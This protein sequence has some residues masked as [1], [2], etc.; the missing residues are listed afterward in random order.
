MTLEHLSLPFVDGSTGA[1]DDAPF[2]PE[3]G[4]Q[5]LDFHF[6]RGFTPVGCLPDRVY[7]AA[8]Q[9]GR[10]H[11]CRCCNRPFGNGDSGGTPPHQTAYGDLSRS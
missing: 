4:L 10:E 11:P 8:V 9:K 5:S 3:A 1:V 2:S 7:R 6:Q